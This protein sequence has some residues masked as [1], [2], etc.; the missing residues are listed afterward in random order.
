MK[1]AMFPEY[2]SLAG[3]PVY[4]AFLESL[5][6]A[7]HTIVKNDDA[8]VAVIWSLL[9]HGRMS[10]NQDI[11]QSYRQRN[12][13][14]IVI[15]VGGL[16]RNHTWKIGINGINRDADFN[17]L[18]SPD[19]RWELL[20]LKLEPWKDGDHIIICGQ[21]GK[22]EQWRE[23]EPVAEW[24][25]N[26]AIRLRKHTKRPIILRPHPRFPITL[27]LDSID[28]VTI[29][30][31][32]KVNGTYDNFNFAN[33]L[34]N[35]HAVVNYSSNPAIEAVLAGV[36]VYVS[37]SSLCYEVGNNIAD[38]S[39]IETPNKP[40]RIQWCNNIAYTEWT[41]DEIKEGLPLQHLLPC[42]YSLVS[43]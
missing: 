1:F 14:V 5:L 26:T 12:K 3:E 25:T 35:A 21:H 42:L 37:Q 18:E 19:D 32:I 34:F 16:I 23:N 7:G 31:P 40:D 8:D 4:Y 30:N 11:W 17:H 20:G 33:A 9:W 2:L 22:S 27:H 36:P 41:V 39:S 28:L 15:E 6:N 13:P 24:M 38:F 43:H 29:I 10:G